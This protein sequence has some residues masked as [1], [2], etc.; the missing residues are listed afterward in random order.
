MKRTALGTAGR[1]G[2]PIFTRSLIILMRFFNKPWD[3]GNCIN[4]YKDNS[5]PLPPKSSCVFCPYQ[6]PTRWKNIMQSDER[7]K[8]IEVDQAIRN[9]SM[10]G[11][12][13]PIYLTKHCLPIDKVKFENIP[14]DMF[15]NECEGYCGL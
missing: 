7:A 13:A 10:K 2:R 12:R 1:S 9:L 8:V 3:R 4:F 6:S 14:D 11:M 15:G 5:L